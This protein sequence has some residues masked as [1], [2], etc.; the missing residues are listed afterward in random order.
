MNHSSIHYLGITGAL[1][2]A[3]TGITG[4]KCCT[5]QQ[6][7]MSANPDLAV[8]SVTCPGSGNRGAAISISDVTTNL[9]ALAAAAASTSYIYMN[10]S[11]SL[12]GATNLGTHAVGAITAKKS[13]PWS[14]SVTIPANQPTGLN[15]LFIVCDKPNVIAESNENNNTNYCTITVN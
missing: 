4:C 6:V 8:F 5:E 3:A 11:L 13:Y 1:I 7:E 10:T 15:Y 9:S 12:S 2:L 14:G